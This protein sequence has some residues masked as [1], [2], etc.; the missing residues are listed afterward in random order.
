VVGRREHGTVELHGCT[1]HATIEAV[2]TTCTA[3]FKTETE[4]NNNNYDSGIT[5]LI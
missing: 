1:S 3:A 2:C 5:A 4:K